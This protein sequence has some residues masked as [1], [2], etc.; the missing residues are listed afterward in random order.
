MKQLIESRI[1]RLNEEKFNLLYLLENKN[2]YDEE[3]IIQRICNI[4]ERI[5]E[6]QDLLDDNKIMENKNER[7]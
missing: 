6:L 5:H 4:N 7:K 3:Y 1:L 2:S